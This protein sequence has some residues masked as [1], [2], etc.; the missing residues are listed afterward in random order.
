MMAT[1][2]NSEE[3]TTIEKLPDEVLLDIFKLLAPKNILNASLVCN[4]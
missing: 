1:K 4:R 3:E 2:N